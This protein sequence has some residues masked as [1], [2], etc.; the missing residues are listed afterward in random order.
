MS[1]VAGVWEDSG[2]RVSI[3]VYP[4]NG[5]SFTGYSQWAIRDGNWLYGMDWDWSVGDFDGDGR[6]DLF[7]AWNDN[8]RSTLTVRKSTGSSFLHQHWGSGGHWDSDSFFC[9]GTFDAL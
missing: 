1:D 3:A 9:S 4:S 5:A 2:S 6:F 7:V 8:G